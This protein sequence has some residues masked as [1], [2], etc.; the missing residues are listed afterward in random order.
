MNLRRL[1]AIIYAKDAEIMRYLWEEKEWPVLRWDEKR[2]GPMVAEV[3]HQ[4]GRLLGRME[5]LGFELREE[6]AFRTLTREVVKTSEIEG[7]ILDV[8]QVRSSLARRLGMD[9]AA[10][11]PS[12]RE[13]DG[14]VE[15]VLDATANFD[16]PLTRKRLFGWHAAL[17]PTGHTGIFRIPTGRWRDDSEGPMRVVSGA[18]GREKVHFVA[19][20][21][22][23]VAAEMN[24]FLSWFNAPPSEAPVLKAALAHL[25]F[26]TI[27]PFADG[28]GRIARAIA[29]MA[30]ARSEGE[31]QRFYGMSA[32]IRQERNAYYKALARAQKAGVDVTE[33][34]AWF[35]GC[36]Q[37]AI[38]G[39]RE[40]LSAVLRK[41]RFWET[42][43]RTPFNDR[44]VK[45]LTL[46]LDGDF[47]G[48]LTSSKWAK[49]ARCSQDTAQ[50]DIAALIQHNILKRGAS[51]GRS[52]SYE[53]AP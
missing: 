37:R 43:A 44:Q 20:P 50:R 35:L 3:R 18:A 14:I 7:E 29:D 24:E 41:A 26:V 1:Q 49:I 10:L 12:E 31:P 16:H 5:G 40:E 8:E 48:K 28:N 15:I 42:Y 13:V 34:L 46:L 45:V 36:L 53:L 17:F 33:W 47:K 21:A 19:P 39:S 32:Q 11:K 2:L 51:G 22:E 38:A 27:H 6:S 30:L 25:R 52:T 4:Q 9:T 23:R